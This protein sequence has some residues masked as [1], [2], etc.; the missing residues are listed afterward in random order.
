MTQSSPLDRRRAGLLLHVT[1]LPSPMVGADAY[2]F[3]DFLAAA[4]YSVWQVLP[5]GPT[6]RD[7]SPYSCLSVHAGNPRL[8]DWP[9]LEQAGLAES[10]ALIADAESRLPPDQR[11][12]YERFCRDNADWLDDYVRFQLIRQGQKDRHWVDWPAAL[13]DRDPAALGEV[14]ADAPVQAGRLRLE[15]FLFF[16]QWS[17]LKQYANRHGIRIFG[18]MP[19][20]AAYDSADV[21][22]QR[23]QF[24]LDAQGRAEVVAGV[25]PDYFSATGQ[26]W[27]NPVYDWETMER[28]GFRWWKRRLQRQLE[29]YDLLRID[30]FR[31]LRAC[32]EIPADAEDAR[33]GQWVHVPGDALL[34]AIEA[35]WGALPLVAEDLGLITEDVIALR[36]AFGIP[37]MTVL[38]FAFSG[39]ADNPHLPA[40]HVED[41]VVYTG[42]HDNDTTL[43]WYESLDDEA[44]ALVYRELGHPPEAMPWAL[45]RAAL[46]SVSRL[47][48][49]PMQ[50]ALGLGRG[51]RMNTP[52]TVE[53]NWQWAFAWDQVS[54]EHTQWLRDLNRQYGRI[55][56]A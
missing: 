1:S 30:H 6:H 40:N 11:R 52:G 48:M 38:Q 23:D 12:R 27:G 39:D 41:A 2:R 26:R 42:T 17:S 50:D 14:E 47:T 28:D 15:Q 4:G 8:L 34:G 46:E 45:V 33:A 37:G 51:H 43:G 29:F 24:K 55:P 31:G 19:I 35:E 32:W 49:L 7:G 10:G 5:L 53:G 44:R 54:A 9:S 16:E 13:R 36:K 22:A 25:P 3:V 56:D 20:F 18:D 21:W